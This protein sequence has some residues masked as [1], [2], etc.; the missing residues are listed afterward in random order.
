M[1]APVAYG[2]PVSPRDRATVTVVALGGALGGLARYSIDQL[3]PWQ[4]TQIPWATLMVNIL[5]C[6]A[7]GVLLVLLTEGPAARW[8][9]RPLLAVGLLGGF[10]TFSALAVEVV[11]L[12]DQGA[13]VRAGSYVL[14]SVVVGLLA[15]WLSTNLTRRVVIGRTR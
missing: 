7:I 11:G 9:L 5:G 1:A 15:V 3:L 8:W 10:T 12:A 6:A 13:L 14:L 2:D 4:P